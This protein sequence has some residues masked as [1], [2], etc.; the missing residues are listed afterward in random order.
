MSTVKTR[1]PK[2]ATVA[3]PTIKIDAIA[4]VFRVIHG[5][6]TVHDQLGMN[7]RV[8]AVTLAT[9]LFAAVMSWANMT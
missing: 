3:G 5:G 9:A 2:V 8:N 1:R 4:L 7:A 6:V